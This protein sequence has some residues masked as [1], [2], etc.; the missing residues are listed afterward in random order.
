M[1]LQGSKPCN[2]TFC[3][4]K[5]LGLFSPPANEVR[6]KVIFWPLSVGSQGAL[7]GG[8]V[9]LHG[10]GS[11]SSGGLPP[12]GFGKT[13]LPE[14]RKAGGTHLTRMLSCSMC[15]R[16]N[17]S[18]R[19]TISKGLSTLSRRATRLINTHVDHKAHATR[20]P[21]WPAAFVR[22]HALRDWENVNNGTHASVN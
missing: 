22:W 13:P 14:T 15:V 11:A 7:P 6:V 12:G 1:T 10:G 9:C 3:V 2:V 19:Q 21:S 8:G 18:I 5:A 20:W 4:L 16:T 17:L